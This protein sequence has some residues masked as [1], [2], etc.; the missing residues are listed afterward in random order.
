MKLPFMRAVATAPDYRK[1]APSALPIMPG[2][3][4]GAAYCIARMGGDFYEFIAAGSNRLIFALFDI[5]GKRAQ[6]LDIAATVQDGMRDAVPKLFSEQDINESEAITELT[7]SVNRAILSQASSSHYSPAFLGCFN[8]GLGTLAYVGAGHPPAL[9]K[10]GSGV[11]T[12][13]STGL[14]LG[15]FSH[16]TYEPQISVLQ[17]GAVLLLASRGLWESQCKGE[18]FGGERLKESLA[19][20][21]FTDAQYL[22]E[23]ILRTVQRYTCA[24]LLH[25]DATVIALLRTN[26]GSN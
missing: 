11:T 26:P 9:I 2:I 13:E 1:P 24:P 19:D 5:S 18:E 7:H 3:D 15:L 22:C 4:V 14:P 6:A 10:D 23:A 25:N 8:L 16:A 20:E 12:L 17:P 21:Q